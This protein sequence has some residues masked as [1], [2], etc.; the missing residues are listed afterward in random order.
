MSTFKFTEMNVLGLHVFSCYVLFSSLQLDAFA[1]ADIKEIVEWCNVTI[2]RGGKVWMCVAR[3]RSVC[4][5][6]KDP[7]HAVEFKMRWL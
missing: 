3:D 5:Y 6:F 7:V 2:S 1:D 4:F